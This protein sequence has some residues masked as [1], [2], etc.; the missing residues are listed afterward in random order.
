MNIEEI[1]KKIK[2]NYFK[3]NKDEKEIIKEKPELLLELLKKTTENNINEDIIEIIKDI[4]KIKL[5]DEM[6]MYIIPLT[7]IINERNNKKELES[8]IINPDK[9]DNNKIKE[10]IKTNKEEIKELYLNEKILLFLLDNKEYEL[11]SKAHQLKN[12]IK[13]ETFERIIKE[14]PFDKYY[15]NPY[16]FYVQ[17]ENEYIQKNDNEKFNKILI[18]NLD[19]LPFGCLIESLKYTEDKEKIIKLINERIENN[20]IEIYNPQEADGIFT[21]EKELVKKIIKKSLEKNNLSI[22]FT[23][24]MSFNEELINKLCEKIENGCKIWQEKIYN[25]TLLKSQKFV[26]TLVNNGYIT[27]A[28]D[29]PIFDEFKNNII[30]KINENP[31][32]IKKLKIKNSKKLDEILAAMIKN[33]NFNIELENVQL[34]EQT[35]QALIKKIVE[36]NEK[37]LNKT[38]LKL[39]ENLEEPQKLYDNLIEQ[40]Q[41]EKIILLFENIPNKI[42]EPFKN[43]KKIEEQIKNSYYIANNLFN[44]FKIQL[45]EDAKAR[46]LYI[47]IS[48]EYVE[49]ILNTIEQNK[50]EK[51]YDDTLFYQIEDYYIKKYNLNK[52]NL[53][54]LNIKFGPNIIQYI[55]NSQIHQIINLEEKKFKKFISLFPQK[56]YIMND[57]E[58][59]YDAFK[60]EEFSIKNPEIKTI[61]PKIKKLINSNDKKYIKLIQEIEIAFDKKII[62]QILEKYPE[63]KYL[64]DNDYYKMIQSKITSENILEKE[65]YI[66]IIHMISEHFIA[67]KREEYR[68]EYDLINE[69]K[70]EYEYD[71]KEIDAEIIKYFLKEKDFREQI[72]IKLQTMDKKLIDECIDYYL[73]HKTEG[74]MYHEQIIKVNIRNI[75][76][77]SK[78]IIKNIDEN[79]ILNYRKIV[80]EEGN[81]KKKHYKISQ[82]TD[83]YKILSNI[84]VDIL[85]KY[86]LNPENEEKYQLL[87]KL[88]NKY[89]LDTL[90]SNIENLLKNETYKLECN[91]ED[92]STFINHF[93]RI[94]DRET[95]KQQTKLENIPLM[96]I[97]K[98]MDSYGAVSSVYSQI[99]GS[100]NARLIRED[101]GPHNSLGTITKQERLEYA[102]KTT[103]KN[104]KRKTVDIP[105]FT[106]TIKINNKEL[107]ATVGN[108]TSSTLI[109]Q[110]ERLGSCMRIDGVAETLYDYIFEKGFSIEFVNP[111][112]L[113]LVTAV[114]GFRGREEN[115]NTVFINESRSS[116]F[117]DQYSNIE[118]IEAYKII[119]QKLIEKSKDST[120][121]IDN[122]IIPRTRIMEEIEDDRI[123]LDIENPKKGLK[124]FYTDVTPLMHVLATTSPSEKFTPVKK[125]E[126]LIP[127]Y[128]PSREIILEGNNKKIIERINRIHIINRILNNEDY[129]RLTP[130]TT[131]IKYGITGEDWYIYI[132]EANNIETEIM[133]RDIRAQEEYNKALE[134]IKG[135]KNAIQNRKSNKL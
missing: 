38:I 82:Q 67:L 73:Y 41:L 66:D 85:D 55:N 19:K 71:E 32:Y 116:L 76:K 11:I 63:E 80:L 54:Q 114:S 12:Y 107:I 77:A 90:P 65:K 128:I 123:K 31:N 99:L 93:Y 62:K 3:F 87:K 83:I 47:K 97:F 126:C 57:L 20:N 30:N 25:T 127:S 37:S 36:T 110:G 52:E 129:K 102:V 91:I 1:S 120:C 5:T 18:K 88:M 42:T 122:V 121:P 119:A 51:L 7:Q 98:Y 113:D 15:L 22:F 53:E 124:D 131:T 105:A 28:V 34:G 6:I 21:L 132:D 29:S 24:Y 23:Q 49:K 86:L 64:I 8:G 4:N 135:E 133:N 94:Y 115:K 69:L 17:T 95:K 130:K 106:E 39:V 108:F 44:I 70:V 96:S 27:Q 74:I 125:E 81:L 13:E 10:Y 16:N 61:F 78:Q 117:K 26:Q 59:V 48:D 84:R 103:I 100:G 68:N 45:I 9:C 33:N 92:I 2:N 35:Q 79:K 104:F 43:I 50:Q 101:P 118:I 40:Q 89:K 134:K 58:T 75:I 46:E 14:F 112:T 72:K 109:T 60:Q 56:E 111:N